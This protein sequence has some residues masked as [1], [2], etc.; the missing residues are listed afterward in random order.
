M[1][2]RRLRSAVSCSFVDLV[3]GLQIWKVRLAVSPN[4]G[5]VIMQ[6]LKRMEKQQDIDADAAIAAYVAQKE[7]LVAERQRRQEADAAAREAARQRN[8]NA[9]ESAF[10]KVDYYHSRQLPLITCNHSIAACRAMLVP[11]TICHRDGPQILVCAAM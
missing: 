9:L 8:I 3:T 2:S 10:L 7:A 6:E 4:L 1:Y 11:R 5:F